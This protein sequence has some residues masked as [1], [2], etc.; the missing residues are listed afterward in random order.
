MI[1]NQLNHQLAQLPRPIYKGNI[2]GNIL[3][4][5]TTQLIVSTC[6][7]LICSTIDKIN[8]SVIC[9]SELDTHAN[10]VVLG[11]QCFVFESIGKTCNVEP[12]SSDLG[13]A[14]TF[15]LLMLH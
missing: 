7:A 8:P 10:M 12:F 3:N 6:K 11:T 4:H 14:E 1:G 13:I 2:V 9:K 15:Q 5:H